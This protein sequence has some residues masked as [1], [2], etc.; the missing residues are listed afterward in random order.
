MIGRQEKDGRLSVEKLSADYSGKNAGEVD[1]RIVGN[2]MM[3]RVARSVLG[4][5][6]GDNNLY[7]KMA[8][9]IEKAD[10]IMDYYVSGK[11]FPVGRLSFRYLG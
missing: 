7:F 11:S 6:A 3:I 4:I 10:D 2:K 9:G 1:F 8:D 5:A